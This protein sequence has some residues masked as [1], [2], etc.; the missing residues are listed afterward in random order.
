MGLRSRQLCP[1]GNSRGEFTSSPF[2]SSQSTCIPWFL[3]P[4]SNFTPRSCGSSL[5]TLSLCHSL[6]H[7]ISLSAT[8]MKTGTVLSKNHDLGFTHIIRII[9]QLKVRNSLKKK[10]FLKFLSGWVFVSVHGL[11]S[12][13]CVKAS[14]CCGFSCCRAQALEPRRHSCGAQAQ[15]LL[16]MCNLPRT[17]TEPVFPASVGRFFTTEPL[18]KPQGSQSQSQL[19]SALLPWKA[20]S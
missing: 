1:P 11:L 16:G 8:T 17:G 7:H 18:A 15:L 9:S 4:F 10:F 12:S 20:N 14:R 19:Q 13:C 3:V 6:Y 2:P 5:S